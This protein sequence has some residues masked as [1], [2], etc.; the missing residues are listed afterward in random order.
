LP[1]NPANY[2]DVVQPTADDLVSSRSELV[3]SPCNQPLILV[4]LDIIENT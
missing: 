4:R 2:V 1:P 3:I